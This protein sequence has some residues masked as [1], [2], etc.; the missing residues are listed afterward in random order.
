[1]SA[2]VFALLAALRVGQVLTRVGKNLAGVDPSALTPA[3]DFKPATTD[4]YDLGETSTPKRWRYANLSRGLVVTHA[5]TASGIRTALAFTGAADLA[6]T[7]STEQPDVLINSARIVTWATGSLAN[8]RFSKFMAPTIAFVGASTCAVA[9]TVYIEGAPVAGTNA[10][11]TSSYALFIGGGRVRLDGPVVF[12]AAPVVHHTSD[13]TVGPTITTPS[14]TVR[15]PSGSTSVTVTHA[16]VAA[17]TRFR[18]TPLTLATNSVHVRA[19]VPGSGSFVLTLSGDPG[20]SH[21]D[22]F[23]E[24]VQPGA[25]T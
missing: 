23:V 13:L 2:N 9:A 22:L 6:R 12:N 7:A 10:T 3:G 1:M 19:C 5:A 8:Q 16:D 25:G 21:C 17:T 20:A 14:M 15:V 4:A 24:L 11:L 18:V